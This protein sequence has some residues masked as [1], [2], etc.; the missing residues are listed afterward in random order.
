MANRIILGSVTIVIIIILALGYYAF[1]MYNSPPSTSPQTPTPTATP[2][3]T[4]TLSPTSSPI[5]TASPTPSTRPTSAVTTD[6]NWGGYA[7]AS[8]FNNPQPVVTGVSGS[9]NV[10]EVAVSQND[11]FSAIWIGIGGTFGKTL[12]Q[13]GTE[14]D[15][16]NGE[17]LYFAW[18][19]FLPYNSITITTI[20][21]FPGDTISASITLSD[22]TLNLWTISITDVSNGQSFNQDFIYGS[23]RLSGEWVVERPLVNNTLSQLA[24]FGTVTFSNCSATLNNKSGNF[25]TL[26]ST[27]IL[28]TNRQKI[29][30]VDVSDPSNNGSSFTINFLCCL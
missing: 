2:S 13:T 28:L 29:Q 16:I 5:P 4:P 26:N 25:S 22:S 11:T 10:P 12:I 27:K 1:T 3:P 8:D 6:L 30:L 7:V 23:S 18:Y 20:N 17:A 21:V 9:W 15:C 14:Q 24:D 19:E